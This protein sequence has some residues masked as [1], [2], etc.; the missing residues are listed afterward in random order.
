[1]SLSRKDYEDV[2]GALVEARPEGW[3]AQSGSHYVRGYGEGES[4]AI[5]CVAGK[6]A[7]VFAADNPR[8]D[9]ARFLRAAGVAE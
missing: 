5:D 8:F 7:D 9:R 6:L 3:A 4:D 2:A 1:M